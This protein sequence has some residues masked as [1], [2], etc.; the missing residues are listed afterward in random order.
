[1]TMVTI[2]YGD[3]GWK[4]LKDTIFRLGTFGQ[5]PCW[6]LKML[7]DLKLFW[8]TDIVNNLSSFNNRHQFDLN[9]VAEKD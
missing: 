1:M 8:T 6:E 2:V 3:V 9:H 7:K 5:F 4:L